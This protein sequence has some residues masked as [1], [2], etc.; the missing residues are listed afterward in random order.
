M[1]GDLDSLFRIT[2]LR[3]EVGEDLFA[4]VTRDLI[5]GSFDKTFIWL[6]DP[7]FSNRI[8]PPCVGLSEKESRICRDIYKSRFADIP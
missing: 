6:K 2:K 8:L 3:W 1:N 7:E 5:S 4:H